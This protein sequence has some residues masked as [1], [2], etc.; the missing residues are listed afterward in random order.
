MGRTEDPRGGGSDG[1][2]DFNAR[3]LRK[4]ASGLVREERVYV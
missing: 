2:S 3:Q 4:V 1:V